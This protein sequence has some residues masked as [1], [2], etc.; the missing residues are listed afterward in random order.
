[1]KKRKRSYTLRARGEKVAETRARIAQATMELHA[2]VGPRETTISAIASRAGVERLTV[3]RHFPDERSL[4]AAC[5]ARFVESNP[6]PDPATW[7][8][9]NEAVA[10][11]RRALRALYAYFSRTHPMLSKLYRDVGDIPALQEVMRQFDGY[12]AGVAKDLA[13]AWPRGGRALEAAARHAVRF[14]TWNSLEAEG[15]SD[16]EKARIIAAWLAALA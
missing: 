6:P 13:N 2:E 3:Y 16:A 15:L 11:A 12:L 1:M 8:A 4:F 9:E 10:R 14:A 5:S 7:A